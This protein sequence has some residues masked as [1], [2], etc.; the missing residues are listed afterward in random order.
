VGTQKKKKGE[1]TNLGKINKYIDKKAVRRRNSNN[2][3][4]QKGG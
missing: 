2:N 3:S 1:K 4:R